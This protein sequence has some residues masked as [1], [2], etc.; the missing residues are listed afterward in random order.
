[1]PLHTTPAHHKQARLT[2]A[3]TVCVSLILC[4]CITI[5]LVH[6][7]C[8]GE[9]NSSSLNPIPSHPANW[10]FSEKENEAIRT[11]GLIKEPPNYSHTTDVWHS[12]LFVI[13]GPCCGGFIACER[14]DEGVSVSWNATTIGLAL[15][16]GSKFS[17]VSISNSDLS[18]SHKD[19]CYRS[20]CLCCAACYGGKSP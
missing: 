16:F 9:R 6:C 14:P 17:P 4:V 5:I 10:Q 7:L 15:L 3:H 20:L 18:H 13:V 19:L 12:V 8:L 1:M 2:V 11:F